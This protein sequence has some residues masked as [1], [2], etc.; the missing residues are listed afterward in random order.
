MTHRQHQKGSVLIVSLVMLVLMTLIAVSAIQTTGNMIQ[1]VGNAQFREE[2]VS[3]GQQ[4]IDQLI[5]S[6]TATEGIKTKAEEMNAASVN[7]DV[8]G[9]GNG[10]YAVTFSP[11]PSCLSRSDAGT[12]VDNQ[13]ILERNIVL[14][15][16]EDDTPEEVAVRDAARTRYQQL[17]T[18]KANKDLGNQC[19]WSLWRVTTAV[20]DTFTGASTVVTQGVRVLIGLDNKVNNCE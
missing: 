3:A 19:F 11:L 20:S 16:E 9:D 2:A 14:N 8:T 18:C 1:I 15:P 7:V 12:Y 5:G 10:D 6:V 4:A 17:T 13:I